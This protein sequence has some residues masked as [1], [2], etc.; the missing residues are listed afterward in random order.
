LPSYCGGG[1][2]PPCRPVL[3]AATGTRPH[4]I[5]W[6]LEV[7]TS[8]RVRHATPAAFRPCRP[9]SPHAARPRNTTTEHSDRFPAL[10]DLRTL[11]FEPPKGTTYWPASSRASAFCAWVKSGLIRK[12][13]S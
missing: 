1:L 8:A 10:N 12:A 4:V 13:C 5:T 11:R 3:V 2:R 9:T 6:H 7:P